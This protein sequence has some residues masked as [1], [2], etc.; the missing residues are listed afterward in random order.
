MMI[1]P[2]LLPKI[3]KAMKHCKECHD[4][5]AT[6]KD[7]END[8]D[9]SINERV[10]SAIRYYKL[11]DGARDNALDILGSLPDDTISSTYKLSSMMCLNCKYDNPGIATSLKIHL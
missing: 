8:E 3:M 2:S 10:D 4:Y 9:L 7:F 1:E 11:R 5:T 6:A